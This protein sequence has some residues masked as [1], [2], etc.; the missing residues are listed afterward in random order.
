VLAQGEES[1]GFALPG[2]LI[3]WIQLDGLIV[4]FGCLIVLAQGEEGIALFDPVGRI[5]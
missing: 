4:S 2:W 3:G 1:I 5:G